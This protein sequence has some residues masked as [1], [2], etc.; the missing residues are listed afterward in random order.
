MTR[1]GL[2]G[3]GN[4]GGQ[5]ARMLREAGYPLTVMDQ[6]PNRVETAV[7][8]GAQAAQTPAQVSDNSDII[9]LSLPGSHIVEAVME[10]PDG[11]L[12]RL[13]EGQLVI[14]TG[15]SR[16]AT[17]VHY[18][19][20]CRDKGAGF[21]DA[22]ITGRQQGWIMMV[23]GAAEEFEKAQ[24]VLSCLSYKLK[25]IGPIGE[26]QLLKLLNQMMQAGQLAIQ[27]ETIAFAERAGLDP[28]LV[29]DYLEY[30]VPDG[31]YTGDF[32]SGGQLSLHYKDLGYALEV[33]HDAG[34]QIPVTSA[35]HE[36]FKAVKLSGDPRWAQLGILTYWQ[37][38]NRPPKPL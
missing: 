35:I 18:E 1:I 31:L 24:P 21:L 37:N 38:L 9:L 27:A 2:I 14:D 19:Q 25:H 30:S 10:G 12:S 32:G 3:I 5:F 29:R 26:G 22:P 13:R 4:V 36:V 16:P 34:A 23:G 20:V 28:R 11:V 17:A 6:N 8:L 33:A 15:T 7:A